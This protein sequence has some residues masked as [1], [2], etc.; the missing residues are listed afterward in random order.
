MAFQFTDPLAQKYFEYRHSKHWTEMY[1]GE[2][3]MR[4]YNQGWND[5]V[6]AFAEE[7]DKQKGENRELL[8]R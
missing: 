6:R 7:F 3:C 2:D 1:W 8:S 4:N 5:C